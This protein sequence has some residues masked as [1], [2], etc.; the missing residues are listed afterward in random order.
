MAFRF[1]AD[2]R[3]IHFCRGGGEGTCVRVVSR[4]VRLQ[5]AISLSR[6]LKLCKLPTL[7]NCSKARDF[8]ETPPRRTEFVCP[9][10]QLADGLDAR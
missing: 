10:P 4:V 6:C 2:E 7:R 1:F 9:T 8:P 3:N 5:V